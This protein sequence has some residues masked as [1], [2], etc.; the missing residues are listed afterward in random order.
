MLGNFL[1]LP[2]LRPGIV[3][4]VLAMHRC[5]LLWDSIT[6]ALNDN[7]SA[8]RQAARHVLV[9]STQGRALFIDKH[10]RASFSSA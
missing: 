7:V 1:V 4:V 3:I 5:Q 6:E 8:L 9:G 10:H 2:C